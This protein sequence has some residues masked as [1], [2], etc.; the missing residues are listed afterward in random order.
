MDDSRLSS[1]LFLDS[2]LQN[3]T[4]S[5]TIKPES[6]LHGPPGPPAS[7]R[8]GIPRPDDRPCRPR[9]KCSSPIRWMSLQIY[10]STQPPAAQGANEPAKSPLLPSARRRTGE[11]KTHRR[12]DRQ[13]VSYLKTRFS[14]AKKEGHE[15]TCTSLRIAIYTNTTV[16]SHPK[17]SPFPPKTKARPLVLK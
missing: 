15:R 9:N 16:S 14:H 11:K 4:M 5:T 13:P 12:A 8:P 17:E 2:R 3:P 10:S 6:F 1:S 7:F